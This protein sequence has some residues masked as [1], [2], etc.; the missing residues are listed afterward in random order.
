MQSFSKQYRALVIGS[1]G[2]IGSAFL[3]LLQSDP[4]CSLAI[5]I[6]RQ[7]DPWIDYSLEDSIE[8]AALA[9]SSTGP[10]HLII[11]AT[12][13]LYTDTVSP[14][15]K[16]DDLSLN[17]LELLMRINAFGPALMMRHFSK[18][19]DKE[20]SVMAVISGR[21]GSIEDNSIGGWY[22][23]RASKTALNMLLK[24]VAIEWKRTRKNSILISLHPGAVESYLSKPFHGGSAK[25]SGS[26]A[27]I[28]M[29]RVIDDL[30][31][32]Q[33]GQFLSYTGEKLPW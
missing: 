14:E 32:A 1:S 11:N 9:L 24:T 22:S 30:K 20:R 29:L 33:S 10:F 5:G 8:K 25:R 13:I 26:E 6:H 3:D 23:Y 28:K 17:K 15:K 19:L 4:N 31:L 2:G 16:L 18:L 21:I 12:G 27:A 7:S